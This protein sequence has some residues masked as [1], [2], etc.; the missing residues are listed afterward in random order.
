MT[1]GEIT[2]YRDRLYRSTSSI[3]WPTFSFELFG[4]T[5]RSNPYRLS[6][7]K[8][9]QVGSYGPDSVWSSWPHS[10]KRRDSLLQVLDKT[11]N[12][13]DTVVKL[14]RE[15]EIKMYE[16]ALDSTLEKVLANVVILLGICLATALALWTSFQT[17][18]ATVT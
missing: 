6:I 10:D 7:K 17:T 11:E 13:L 14:L 16:K 5:E 8:S 15:A 4:T 9:D 18:N 12:R 2:R 1:H 3:V